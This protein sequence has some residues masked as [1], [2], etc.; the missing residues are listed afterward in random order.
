MS[1]KKII[2]S[3]LDRS[4]EF[5]SSQ[6]KQGWMARIILILLL[7]ASIGAIWWSV[8]ERLSL[9][10]GATSITQQQADIQRGIDQ[11]QMK[12]S[13]QNHEKIAADLLLAED[14]LMPDQ[15]TMADWL[16]NFISQAQDRRIQLVYNV[17][18]AHPSTDKL[19]NIHLV[20][21]QIIL[22][23]SATM[24][25]SNAYKKLIT[26]AKSITN[27]EW[28]MD[29]TNASVIGSREQFEQLEMHIEMWML[30]EVDQSGNAI[31]A[32]GSSS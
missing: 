3:R 4:L 26:F 30:G 22:R 1:D 10:Y 19:S 14:K 9:L 15:N 29:V 21:I 2:P 17:G 24:K 11:S 12:W 23:P 8:N 7:L 5:T 13:S 16:E 6:L 25:Q 31:P 28:R 18:R 32:G 27:N 20:P